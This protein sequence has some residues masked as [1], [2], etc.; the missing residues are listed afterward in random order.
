MP[1]ENGS[2]VPFGRDA[3]DRDRHLLP[4]RPAESDIQ[5]AVA[6]EHGVVDLVEPGGE[7]RRDVDERDRLQ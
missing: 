7:R 6:I 4:S 5:V 3:K 1:V 2:L